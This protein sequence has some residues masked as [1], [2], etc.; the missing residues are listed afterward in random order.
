MLSSLKKITA[1]SVG[2]RRLKTGQY[3]A[4]SERK[5]YKG[6]LSGHCVHTFDVRR[7]N[8][9]LQHLLKDRQSMKFIITKC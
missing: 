9:F 3:L 6:T 4:K 8:A 2:E 1:K 5:Y 7:L